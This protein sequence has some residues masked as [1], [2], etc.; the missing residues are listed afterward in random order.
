MQRRG[1][2]VINTTHTHTHTH[3]HTQRERERERERE[4]QT[5]R[6]TDRKL[7]GMPTRTLSRFK[8][9]SRCRRSSR[10]RSPGA[11]RQSLKTLTNVLCGG[12]LMKCTGERRY[13]TSCNQPYIIFGAGT[14]IV[15][16]LTCASHCGIGSDIGEAAETA[17]ESV[18]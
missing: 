1:H 14:R 8:E 13:D 7:T 17:S 12:E 5:D 16:D 9:L 3:T 6:Q 11:L 10:L 4:R 15:P 18:S 2:E